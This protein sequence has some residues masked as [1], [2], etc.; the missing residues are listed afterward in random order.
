[1]HNAVNVSTRRLQ[2]SLHGCN[3]L[4]NTRHAM[5]KFEAIWRQA[6]KLS[7][8]QAFEYRKRHS[9]GFS[10]PVLNRR[11]RDPKE[12]NLRRDVFVSTSDTVQTRRPELRTSVRELILIRCK[13]L[14]NS[15]QNN[16]SDNY[17]RC[18]KPVTCNSKAPQTVPILGEFFDVKLAEA[19][20]NYS[21]TELPVSYRLRLEIKVVSFRGGGAAISTR[22]PTVVPVTTSIRTDYVV[23]P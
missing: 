12:T 9:F 23:C 10:R 6:T 16:T 8:N 17:I 18:R 11:L 4:M 13:N 7:S 21:R 5:A 2:Q 22:M 14:A 1:V 3:A 15:R 19:D 20:K